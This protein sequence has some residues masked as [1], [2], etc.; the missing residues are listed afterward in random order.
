MA[1]SVVG[2]MQLSGY[3]LLVNKNN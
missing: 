2:S 1:S 3:L